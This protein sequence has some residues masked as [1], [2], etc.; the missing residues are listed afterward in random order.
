MTTASKNKTAL[1]RRLRVKKSLNCE[2]IPHKAV[3]YRSL[4][5]NSVQLVD[6]RTGKTVA[7][8]SDITLKKGGTK[9]EKA[10][11]VGLELAKKARELNITTLVFDRSSYKYHGRVKAIAEGLRE[12]GLQF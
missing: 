1:K 5:H 6:M 7:S 2:K 3:V 10:K 9:S 12:G 8:A 11:K 4:T